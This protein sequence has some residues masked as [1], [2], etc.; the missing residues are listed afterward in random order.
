MLC[1][2][3]EFRKDGGKFKGRVSLCNAKDAVDIFPNGKT[4]KDCAG[5]AH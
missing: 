1:V 4:G 3:P 2:Y 5:N